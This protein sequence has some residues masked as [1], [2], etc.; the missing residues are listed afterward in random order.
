VSSP[1]VF[2]PVLL[3]LLGGIVLW[4][5][6]RSL[7]VGRWG[8]LAL[9]AVTLGVEVALLGLVRARGVQV[10]FAGGWVPPFGITLVVDLTSAIMLVVS[11]IVGLCVLGHAVQT[12]D[13]DRERHGFYALYQFL[14]MGINGAFV[15]GDIFNLFVFFEVMLIASY[16][17][18]S[19]GSEPGQLR[20]GVHY[21]VTNLVSS[22]L[23]VAAV[24]TLY[25]LAGTLNLADLA[26]KVARAPDPAVF[27]I[28]AA[29]FIVVFG[30]KSA[31]FPLYFWLP[32]S[33][34][35]APLPVT[36]VFAG[37]LTKV[38][39]YAVLRVF[40]LVF[41]HDPGYL[42]A[43]LLVVAGFT[44][45]LGV[46][47]A[48]G[49]DNWKRILSVHIVSQVGYMIMG[50]GFLSV[51]G[52]AAA[53]FFIVHQILVKTA[54]FLIAGLAERA[55]GAYD[56]G[57]MGGLAGRYPVMASL[58]MVAGLSLAGVPPLSGF[59]G[60]FLL[61]RAGLAQGEVAVVAVAIVVSFFTLYSMMKIWRYAFWGEEKPAGLRPV[62]AALYLPAAAL[63]AFSV[64]LG[65]GGEALL[66]LSQQAA[67]QL[68]DGTAYVMAVLGA[69]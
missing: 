5:A 45:L 16:A 56:L 57:E 6:R 3:P 66:V 24:G 58:F 27:T 43:A 33:Y 31:L 23:F 30:V 67:A 14:F 13:P 20:G 65:L 44:M 55:T 19:L 32:A 54:L 34:P 69:R 25:G 9:A 7:G 4:L 15:T 37:M 12:L 52:L 61:I 60:K 28:P 38:G 11:G 50:I 1:L 26:V 22:T 62:P 8:S 10:M 21:L 29:V 36:A 39:V 42:H 40:S 59:F 46:L 47:G 68:L 48:V 49:Y 64:V 53:I 35:A 51:A 63:V 2:L 17:L 41:T 18:V